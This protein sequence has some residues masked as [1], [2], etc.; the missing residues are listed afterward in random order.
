MS[1]GATRVRALCLATTATLLACV[2]LVIAGHDAAAVVAASLAAA[3]TASAF[4]LV[5]APEPDRGTADHGGTAV[6][7]LTGMTNRP[8]AV[9]ELDRALAAAGDG[10]A[11]AVLIDIDRF[12]SVNDRYGIGAGDALLRALG[13]RIEAVLEADEHAARVGGDEFLITSTSLPDATAVESLGRRVAACFE[14]P[15]P[16]GE[17][18]IRVDASIGVSGQPLARARSADLLRDVD[19]AV[20][21]AKAEAGTAVVVCSPALRRRSF[22]RLA[23]ESDLRTAF[24]NNQIEIWVQPIVDAVTHEVVLGEV[25]LRWQREGTPIGPAVF[26]PVAEIIDEIIP[27]TRFILDAVCAALSR[28]QRA[29]VALPLAVNVSATHVFDGRLAA[30]VAAALERHRTPPELL[31]LEITETRLIEHFSRVEAEI[32]DLKA[33][34]CPVAIDDFGSGYSSVRYLQRIPADRVKLDSTIVADVTA[35]ASHSRALLRFITDLSHSLGLKVVAEGV[36]TDDQLAAI[37]DAGVEYAQGHRFAAAMPLEAFA[38]DV[39]GY[40]ERR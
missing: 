23:I 39:L 11:G 37:V 22:E 27:L 28:W 20:V 25:L 38:T 32:A 24:E 21:E 18:A 14:T 12:R 2:V 36:E 7:L 19:L 30:D 13:S 26:I 40:P 6:D 4:L 1:R 3:M 16:V 8:A 29:G 9:A 17:H 5:D 31:E 34:G 33:L 10:H 35:A 15:F